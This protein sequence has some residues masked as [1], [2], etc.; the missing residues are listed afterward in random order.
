MIGEALSQSPECGAA[1]ASS[2]ALSMSVVALLREILCY[3][4]AMIPSHAFW[5]CC[6]SGFGSFVPERVFQCVCISATVG[7]GLDLSGSGRIDCCNESVDAAEAKKADG[8]S[9]FALLIPSPG[10]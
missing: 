10:W 6:S 2:L 9:I 5:I 8:A 3:L 1:A 7:S 4:L